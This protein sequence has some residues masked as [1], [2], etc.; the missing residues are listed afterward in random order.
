MGKAA[1][2]GKRKRIAIVGLGDIAH[3]VYV[4]LLSA[5]S[6]VELVGVVSR[7]ETTVQQ[8]MDQYRIV[9][10]STELH[11]LVKWDVDA[12][13]VHSPTTTH[14]EVVSACLKMGLPVYVDKPLAYELKQAERLAALAEQKGVLLAVGFNRRFAPLYKQASAWLAEAGGFELC[15]VSK[16]RTRLQHLPARETMYD[17]LIHMLDLLVWLGNERYDILAHQLHKQSNDSNGA[18]LHTSGMLSLGKGRYGQ[19][20][21]ARNAGADLE[22]L[23]LHGSGCSAEVV[24][25]EQLYLYEKDT[26]PQQQSPGNW[27]SIWQRRGFTGVV[28]H[29]WSH[30]DTPQ[31]C[32]IRADLVLDT[33]RLVEELIANV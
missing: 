10:G 27:E 14:F 19:Y 33:H 13:F 29:F 21:M 11:E 15:E 28:E 32:N 3:K 6:D 7:T 26:L 24:N 12:V 4:P 1:G 9:H 8:T 16:H 17:D 22:K 18:L 2:T 31:Q 23:V 30:L 20:S 5:H 25:M